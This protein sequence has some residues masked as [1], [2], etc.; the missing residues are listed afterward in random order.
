MHL[1]MN[2]PRSQATCEYVLPSSWDSTQLQATH[3]SRAWIATTT[4]RSDEYKMAAAG[5]RRGASTTS[6]IRSAAHKTTKVW[7]SHGKITLEC[8]QGSCRIRGA[9]SARMVQVQQAHA[10]PE[11][12]RATCAVWGPHLPVAASMWKHVGACGRVAHTCTCMPAHLPEYR[13]TRGSHAPM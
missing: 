10:L 1:P 13:P 2:L 8:Y 7:L 12:A 11:R 9:M 6:P 3:N 5:C 4:A